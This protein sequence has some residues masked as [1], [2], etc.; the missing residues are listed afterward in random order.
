MKA[1]K[2]FLALVLIAILFVP[3]LSRAVTVIP[4]LLENI[5]AEKGKTY[6]GK[7]S[8]RNE[9]D[10]AHTYYL[11]A[12]NFS[13]EGEEG[14]PGFSEEGEN[15]GLAS[16]I[17]YES[18]QITLNVGET[19]EVKFKINVPKD[20]EPG[21]HYAA[22]FTSTRP[23]EEA[24]KVGLGERVGVL[25]LVTV[26]GNIKENAELVEFSLASGKKVYN[27]PPVE[28]LIRIK[29]TGN[30]HFKPLGNIT[31]DGWAGEKAKISANPVRGNVLP[32]SVRALHPIWK[33][34]EQKGGF[35]EELKNEWNNFGFG[36]YNAHLEMEWGTKGEKFISNVKFWLFPWRVLLVG[37]LIVIILI[38]LIRRYNKAIVK[39]AQK[40]T[41][42]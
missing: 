23:P 2:V 25:L 12:Q 37:A 8:I 6:N 21:G 17:E 13:A 20:A 11:I 31:I 30:V 14:V 42:K 4:P 9:T 3:C 41:K 7:F 38:V 1:S 5:V 32:K 27:R 22:I 15:I 10:A 40:K 39:K 28:F 34:P 18:P 33:G 24:S 35:M 16:W 36:R 29:N 19:K 26:P